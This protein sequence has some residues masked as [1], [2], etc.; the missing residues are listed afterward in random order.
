MQTVLCFGD[1]NTW[2][3]EASTGA[4][5]GRW[6]R[7]PGV[8]Q[9]EL[10]EDVYV[11][12]EGLGGRTTTFEIPGL[13]NRNGFAALPML[14]E[15]HEPLDLV[16]ISLGT[17]DMW[18]PGATARDAARGVGAMVDVVRASTLG[19]GEAAPAVLVVVPPPLAALSEEWTA[20]SDDLVRESSRFG[21]AYR[22]VLRAREVPLVDLG[23]LIS[24]SA[25]DGIHFEAQDHAA[26]GRAVAAA[27]RAALALPA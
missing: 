22:D 16:V 21:D 24:S 6:Q 7:W 18:V 4:R 15:T 9:Q 13:P 23:E 20:E 11:I 14:L 1:S 25:A 8:A 10:G 26:I 12:E 19:P 5:L 17:N 3:Y 27:V 2:G